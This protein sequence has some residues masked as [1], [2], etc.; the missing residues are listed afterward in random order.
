[1]EKINMEK[2]NMENNNTKINTKIDTKIGVVGLGYVGLPLAVAFS[3]KFPLIGFDVKEKR[4]QELKE[5]RDST[6]EVNPAD[7]KRAGIEFTSSPEKIKDCN[8]IIAAVP[9]PITGEKKPDLF[10]VKSASEVI[11]R[12]LSAGSIVVFESTVY[13]GV[14]ED[15]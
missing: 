1:M 15:V 7:L 3:K 11:G 12:N 9:T 6:G 2:I 10:F 4:I 8:F 13:P 14:T 5:G